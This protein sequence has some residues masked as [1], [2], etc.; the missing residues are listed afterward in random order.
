MAASALTHQNKL[1]EHNGLVILAPGSN[2]LPLPRE[3]GAKCIT[4]EGRWKLIHAAGN[5]ENNRLLR[6]CAFL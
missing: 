3:R 2:Q 4:E 5:L 1:G 6:L